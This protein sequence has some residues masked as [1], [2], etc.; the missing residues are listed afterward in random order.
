MQTT[1]TAGLRRWC[2]ECGLSSPIGQGCTHCGEAPADID[3]AGLLEAFGED[4]PAL[5]SVPAAPRESFLYRFFMLTCSIAMWCGI[6]TF[7]TVVGVILY[8]V[9]LAAMK[10]H[11]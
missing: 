2:R 6:L 10:A 9:V 5:Q 4:E 1:Q 8:F 3:A 11:G 7:V